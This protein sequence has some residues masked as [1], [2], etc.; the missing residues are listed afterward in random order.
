MR[1]LDLAGRVAAI[2]DPIFAEQ[3]VAEGRTRLPLEHTYYLGA[4]EVPSLTAARDKSVR[5]DLDASGEDFAQMFLRLSRETDGRALFNYRLFC[6]DMDELGDLF[7]H[8]DK[9]LPSLGDAGAH[10]SQ[11]IDADWATFVL[12]Y[13]IR[14]RGVYSLPGG[15]KRMTSDGARVMGLSDRGM[16]KVGQR[17]DINVFDFDR[18][19][20]LQPEIVH[21]FP[22]GAPHFTQRARGYKATLVN[23]KVN[24]RDDQSTGARAGMVLRHHAR[25]S[26]A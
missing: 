9:V 12:K 16:L 7:R 10:V 15:I 18:V 3:L 22:G 20:Q 11:I 1:A 24:V 14:E 19:T 6:Q 5:N 2:K 21:N 17:A 23:G 13:W 25:Q 4:G 8:S 26:A